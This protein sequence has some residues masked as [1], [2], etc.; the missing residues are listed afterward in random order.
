M[1]TEEVSLRAVCRKRKAKRKA[2]DLLDRAVV[3]DCYVVAGW[4]LFEDEIKEAAAIIGR[5]PSALTATA[6]T[7]LAVWRRLGGPLPKIERSLD[8]RLVVGLTMSEMMGF[9]EHIDPAA[10]VARDGK[11]PYIYGCRHMFASS[12]STRKGGVRTASFIGE[13]PSDEDQIA[14]RF[15][16]QCLEDFCSDGTR[17]RLASKHGWERLR[18]AHNGPSRTAAFPD[19]TCAYSL[20]CE[21][22]RDDFAPD[23]NRRLPTTWRKLLH[24]ADRFLSEW[25]LVRIE[26]PQDWN[27]TN[28]R[29]GELN[30]WPMGEP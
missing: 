12:N 29:P 6:A 13:N 25:E 15:V 27:G 1:R 26:S 30:G 11:P 10:W 8:V 4:P 21:L 2:I 17:Y 22:C 23:G 19:Y 24:R 16:A 20:G 5:R 3:E 18:I 9:V 7:P 28:V 14:E